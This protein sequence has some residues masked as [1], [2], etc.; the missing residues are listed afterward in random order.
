RREAPRA[1]HGR[2]LDLLHGIVGCRVEE[3]GGHRRAGPGHRSSAG[4]RR[5]TQD[6]GGSGVKLV[7]YLRVS[8]DRQV[9]EGFGLDVQEQAI[10]KWVKR[11]GHRV[12]LWTRD[13]GVSGANGI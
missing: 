5:S 1:R 2:V 3:A 12:V 6:R 11:E 4:E 9:E 7:A 10:R 8:T 13:E